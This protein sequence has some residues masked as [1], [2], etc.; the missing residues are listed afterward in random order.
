MRFKGA[1]F[2]LWSRCTWYEYMGESSEQGWKMEDDS[3]VAVMAD[4]LA[5][6]ETSIEMVICGC[7]KN[8]YMCVIEWMV[9]NFIWVN[10]F[11]T[12]LLTHEI[13]ANYSKYYFS[14]VL[15]YNE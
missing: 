2:E 4:I 8:K 1:V 13:Q 3:L 7:K 10:K 6:P 15:G 11:D 14:I 5:A 9:L 12:R